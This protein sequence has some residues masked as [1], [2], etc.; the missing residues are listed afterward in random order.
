MDDVIQTFSNEKARK[1][2]C[3]IDEEERTSEQLQR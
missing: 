1:K 2:L 3:I